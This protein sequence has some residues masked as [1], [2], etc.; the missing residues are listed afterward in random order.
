[1]VPAPLVTLGTAGTL[2][3][4]P[5]R[6]YSAVFSLVLPSILVYLDGLLLPLNVPCGASLFI[7]NHLVDPQGS[8]RTK[9]H[10][11]NFTVAQSL[12]FNRPFLG[13]VLPRGNL[14]VE[15]LLSYL[16]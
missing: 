10:F 2:A 8:T 13:V 9:C 15:L 7:V 6:E 11:S 16:R 12:S 1:M 14:E 3:F 5:F 4:A